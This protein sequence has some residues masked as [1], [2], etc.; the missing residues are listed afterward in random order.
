MKL[1]N[2]TKEIFEA[3]AISFNPDDAQAELA[4]KRIQICDVC[5]HKVVEPYIHCNQC[6]CALKAKIYTPK[7]YKD[8]GGSCPKTKWKEVEDEYL[9]IKDVDT[10]NKLKS[11]KEDM[12]HNLLK[13][14]AIEYF[15]KFRDKDLEALSNLYADDIMA[16]EVSTSRGIWSGKK[17]VLQMNSD[18]F[19]SNYSI[20]IK[21][22]AVVTEDELYYT[23]VAFQL[24]ENNKVISI[25]H[26]IG[27][28]TEYKINS[29]IAKTI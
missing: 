15:K 25:I 2:K 4:S 13:R 28:N 3:W 8:S 24:T 1:L 26:K 21:D 27:F 19:N 7:T 6:G 11:N 23:N 14:Y 9:K 22:I 5:E 17:S 18:Y 10:Y 12:E 20:V 16:S 29:I